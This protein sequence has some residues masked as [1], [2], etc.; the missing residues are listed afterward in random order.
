MRRDT[1]EY[2]GIGSKSFVRVLEIF[3]ISKKSTCK[4]KF[5]GL[6]NTRCDEINLNASHFARDGKFN[7][8][9]APFPSFE[10]LE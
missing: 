2:S 5:P 1:F 7:A 4:L 6:L 8:Q 3:K 10:A 9:M